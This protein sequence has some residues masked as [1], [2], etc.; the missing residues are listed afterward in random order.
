MIDL[1]KGW[2]LLQ[3]EELLKRIRELGNHEQ[4][5]KSTGRQFDP[6]Q[7]MQHRER[8]GVRDQEIFCRTFELFSFFHVHLVLV[9]PAISVVFLRQRL[10][11]ED[12]IDSM[13]N[14]LVMLS[15]AK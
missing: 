15:C 3:F 13:I 1:R 7:L 4:V 9:D 8:D 5:G 2:C 6:G 11:K 10:Q 12:F 14:E